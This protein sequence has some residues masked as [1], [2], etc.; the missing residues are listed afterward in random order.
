MARSEESEGR[1]VSEQEDRPAGT[2]N[3]CESV[4]TWPAMDGR[5]ERTVRCVHPKRHRHGHSHKAYGICW[6]ADDETCKATLVRRD[7]AVQCFCPAGHDGPHEVYL[8]DDQMRVVFLVWEATP[9]D[10]AREGLYR[11]A[12]TT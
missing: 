9:P 10:V 12:V 11:P 6:L 1:Q 3:Q 5:P 7:Y 8:H 2:V 4:H